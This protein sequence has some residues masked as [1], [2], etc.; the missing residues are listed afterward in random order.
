M[1]LSIV[2]QL[3][4]K[5]LPQSND[6]TDQ[7][8]R[9]IIFYAPS[10]ATT[11]PMALETPVPK[12]SNYW[13]GRVERINIKFNASIGNSPLQYVDN[14]CTAYL[15][16]NHDKNTIRDPLVTLT[17]FRTR[18]RKY[19][20]NILQLA[21]AGHEWAR[22]EEVKKSIAAVVTSFEE[23]LCLAEGDPS[24]LA[25]SHTEGNMWYQQYYKTS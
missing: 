15:T 25:T 16:T 10:D 2:R 24:E 8:P 14:L 20:E 13:C 12:S 17:N 21:G 1:G 19:Q 4:S 6:F 5:Y 11:Q 3:G 7:Y 18:V 22:S 9:K 23:I